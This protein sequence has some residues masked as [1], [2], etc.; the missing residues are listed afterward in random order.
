MGAKK[1]VLVIIIAQI[2]EL[3]VIVWGVEVDSARI[4]ICLLTTL[5]QQMAQFFVLLENLTVGQAVDG[6][7]YCAD[8]LGI[9]VICI[10]SVDDELLDTCHF[11]VSE[12][13]KHLVVVF[14][15]V[16]G[17]SLSPIVGFALFLVIEILT[18][19]FFGL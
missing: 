9:W 14:F 2:A 13:H 7:L 11:F 1:L 18:G 12:M 15:I 8:G 6:F 17:F 4:E 10:D 19:Q 3:I 5:L 16:K